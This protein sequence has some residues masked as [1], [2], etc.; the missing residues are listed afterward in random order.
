MEQ[1][2]RT[3]R[4]VNLCSQF[5]GSENQCLGKI[6][7]C[8]SHRKSKLC[9]FVN[10]I[11]WMVWELIAQVVRCLSTPKAIVF[12]SQNQT[13]SINTTFHFLD[14]LNEFRNRFPVG[15]DADAFEVK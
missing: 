3:I 14:D 2:P 9:C 8:K 6:I 13:E 4:L 11:E 15:M 1:K 7:V 10:R 5:T 12:E